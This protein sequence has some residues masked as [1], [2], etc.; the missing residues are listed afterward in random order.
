MQKFNRRPSDTLAIPKAPPEGLQAPVREILP[1]E[2]V[3]A[4]Q[5]LQ[6]SR[7][8]QRLQRQQERT[9]PTL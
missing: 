1:T 5:E 8:R 6:A 9:A 2:T 7:Q 4:L 3:K